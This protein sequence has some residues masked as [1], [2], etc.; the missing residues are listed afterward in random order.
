[1]VEIKKYK[2]RYKLVDELSTNIIL[3]LKQGIGERDA[4][5]MLLSGGSTP[6]PLY[7]KMSN[8]NLDWQKIWFAPTDERWVEPDHVDSNEKMIRNTLLVNN[9]KTANYIGLKVDGDSPVSCAPAVEEKL[10][11][12]P[13][14][15]DVVLLGMGEDGHFASLF[16]YLDDTKKAMNLNGA[17]LCSAIRREGVEHDRVTMSYK[18]ILSA[19]NIIVLFYG[20][21]K[22][23]VFEQAAKKA[24]D[25]LPI[26]HLL[27]QTDVPVTLYWAE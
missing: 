16:P 26:S 10:K 19:K 3:M 18:A 2:S 14:P 1:L 12:I 11:K 15:F 4:G 5:S 13:M 8:R 27:N 23:A 25:Q 24:N 22:L 9:A 17:S 6:G 21:T 7:E 20:K